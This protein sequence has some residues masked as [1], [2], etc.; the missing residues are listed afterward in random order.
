MITDPEAIR[1][2]NEVVRPLCERVR[3]LRADINSAR[4]AYDAG[5]GDLFFSH[6]AEAVSDGREAEGVSRLVG[7]DVLAFV[8]LVLDSMKNTLNDAG[9]AAV[10]AKPCVRALVTSA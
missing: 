7:N 6:G 5:I 3:G 9:N 2:C 4:A 10:V 1:F 8:A